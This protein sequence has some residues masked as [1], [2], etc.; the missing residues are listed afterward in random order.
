MR[1]QLLC[2]GDKNKQAELMFN[3]KYS[4]VPMLNK[5]YQP[6]CFVLVKIQQK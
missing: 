6:G 2:L 1:V 3:R 5:D 4:A